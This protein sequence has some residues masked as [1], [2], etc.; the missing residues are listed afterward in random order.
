MADLTVRTYDPNQIIVSY[1]GVPLVGFAEGTFVTIKRSGDLFT[2]V[3]G[4][5]G[6]VDRVNNN[7]FD[8]EVSIHL[9][10]V[11]PSNAVLSLAASADQLSN[12]GTGILLIKDNNGS[13][14]FTAAQ[15][16]VKKDP[17]VSY[18]D[19]ME[20]REWTFDTGVG[21]LLVGGN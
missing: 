11:S 3:R 17:D 14:L 20:S 8:F 18:S 5:D 10:Q 16:W 1:D 2:K 19:K 15:A 9:K 6:G 12:A 13:T 4:A 7:N 21:A